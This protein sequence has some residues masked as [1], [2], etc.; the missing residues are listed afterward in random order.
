[1]SNSLQQHGIKENYKQLRLRMKNS[2]LDTIKVH[3]TRRAGK[4]QYTFTG[5]PEQV[6]TAEKILA[7]WA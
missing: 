6:V 3:V 7:D 2:G 5:S 4:F 1:M